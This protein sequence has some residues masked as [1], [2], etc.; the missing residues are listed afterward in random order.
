MATK[1]ICKNI[2][3]QRRALCRKFVSALE[4]AKGKSSNQVI[5]SEKVTSIR[6]DIIKELWN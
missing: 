2:R 3:I 1:N 4:H 5:L 6:K